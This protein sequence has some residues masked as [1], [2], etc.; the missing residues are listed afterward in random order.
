MLKVGTPVTRHILT[1]LPLVQAG[2]NPR[3]VR[4]GFVLGRGFSS[5]TSVFSRAYHLTDAR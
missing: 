5:S 4:V 1:S 2:P 3:P